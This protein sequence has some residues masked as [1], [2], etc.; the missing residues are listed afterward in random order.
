MPVE[1]GPWV[2]HACFCQTVRISREGNLTIQHVIGR[3]TFRTDDPQAPS[4]M[5][6]LIHTLK[7][8]VTIVPAAGETYVDI[9]L[10]MQDPDGRRW[11]GGVLRVPPEPSDTPANTIV[12]P[13]EMTFDRPGLYFAEVWGSDRL[14][15]RVPL[16]VVYQ[17]GDSASDS[18]AHAPSRAAGSASQHR[19]QSD[20]MG[21]SAR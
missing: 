18:S 13:F 21:P 3:L 15:T 17:R 4:V 9:A 2:Q 6:T 20:G 10:G 19:G 5:P 1:G 8:I 11:R 16:D 12:V 7:F 14:L